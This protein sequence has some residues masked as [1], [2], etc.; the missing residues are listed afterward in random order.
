[1]KDFIVGLS[2]AVLVLLP[3]V[4]GAHLSQVISQQQSTIT[5]LE[6]ALEANKY[7]LQ[8]CLRDA[9]MSHSEFT[10]E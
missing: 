2:A 8:E 5:G 1:M 4:L 7:N 3:L 10:G 6:A 9:R